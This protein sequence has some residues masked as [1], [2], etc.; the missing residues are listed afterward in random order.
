MSPSEHDAFDLTSG[1]AVGAPEPALFE[2][3]LEAAPDALVVVDA[4]G[5]IVFVNRQTE[6]LFGY[7]RGELIGEQVER[8]VPL[9]VRARH[10]AHRTAYVEAPKLRPMGVGLEL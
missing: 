2:Q 3:L 5:K 6:A 9:A 10:V 7:P 8:L 1:T 4:I